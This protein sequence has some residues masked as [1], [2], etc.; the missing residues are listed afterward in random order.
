MYNPLGF[1]LQKRALGN[2][3]VMFCWQVLPGLVVVM[4]TFPVV[5]CSGVACVTSEGKEEEVVGWLVV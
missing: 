1:P 4:G 3:T 2:T 5:C